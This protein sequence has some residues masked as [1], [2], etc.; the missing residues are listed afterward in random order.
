MAALGIEQILSGAAIFY[1]GGKMNFTINPTVDDIFTRSQTPPPPV[2]VAPIVTIPEKTAV[3]VQ[4]PLAFAPVGRP[5]TYAEAIAEAKK[6][7]EYVTQ[8]VRDAIAKGIERN[9]VDSGQVDENGNAK[10]TLPIPEIVIGGQVFNPQPNAEGWFKHPAFQIDDFY[11]E[12]SFSKILTYQQANSIFQA[13]NL[14]AKSMN[15]PEHASADIPALTIIQ[16]ELG[17]VIT[18]V[19]GGVGSGMLAQFVVLVNNGINEMKIIQANRAYA[20]KFR[21]DGVAKMIELARSVNKAKMGYERDGR[22]LPIVIR[23]GEFIG[24]AQGAPD[25]VRRIFNNTGA[26]AQLAADGSDVLNPGN[27]PLTVVDKTE[28]LKE[29]ILSGK[30]SD[31]AIPDSAK[32]K[33]PSKEQTTVF[34]DHTG[35]RVIGLETPSQPV[36]VNNPAPVNTQTGNEKNIG[37]LIGGI[38]AGLLFFL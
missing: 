11:A 15:D 24:S 31:Y 4:K 3:V 25:Y 19:A 10:L 27:P 36:V 2:V 9:L 38:I 26:Y 16:Q 30:I 6:G 21:H 32:N 29:D 23:L 8:A 37:V 20:D 17:V 18:T 28:K 13:F 33:K 1:F 34:E 22:F 5:Y 12:K 35:D 14:M 7:K